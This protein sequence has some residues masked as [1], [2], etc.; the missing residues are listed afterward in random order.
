M[1][2]DERLSEIE[3]AIAA[4]RMNAM[5]VFTKMREIMDSESG[6]IYRY[7]ERLERE[8]EALRHDL[9]RAMANH[10]ADLNT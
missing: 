8:N 6:Q 1:S 3:D 4:G 7:S 2:A 10:K 9:E 5:Q